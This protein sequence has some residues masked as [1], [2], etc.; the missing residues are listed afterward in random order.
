MQDLKVLSN[1]IQAEQGDFSY[2]F[3]ACFVDGFGSFVTGD[4]ADFLKTAGRPG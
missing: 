2:P 4:F 3:A 1:W